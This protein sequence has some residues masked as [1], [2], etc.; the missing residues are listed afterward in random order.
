VKAYDS[1]AAFLRAAPGLSGCVLTD[2]RMPEIDGLALQETLNEHGVQLPVI[3][4]TGHA[5]VPLAV[6]A[7]KAGAID[8]L[9]KPFEDAQLL[10]AVRR[11]L[12]ESRRL[13][14]ATAV[15]SDAAAR[16][17]KLTPRERE[18][19]D[20]VV[21]GFPNKVIAYE[22]GASQRTIEVHRSRVLEKLQA[23]SL[24]E[25]IRIVLAATAEN[26]VQRDR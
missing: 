13:D 9:E 1:A 19:L 7:L 15:R 14:Q 5:D 8:F 26:G 17:A 16:L 12:E 24:P 11:A 22:L 21:K 6:R 18:V 25:L 2:V 23:R 4:M 10:D 20:R 3:V